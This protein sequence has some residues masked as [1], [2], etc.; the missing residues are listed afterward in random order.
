MKRLVTFC[1]VLLFAVSASAEFTTEEKASLLQSRDALVHALTLIEQNCGVVGTESDCGFSVQAVFE[2]A[3]SLGWLLH[4]NANPN[5]AAGQL[6]LAG[7]RSEVVARA[8][9][10]GQ[11][12]MS[13][14]DRGVYEL[15]RTSAAWKTKTP[16]IAAVAAAGAVN[17]TLLYAD[18]FPPFSVS[19]LGTDPQNQF[20]PHGAYQLAQNELWNPYQ[21]F[22][23]SANDGW[24]SGM[25][26]GTLGACPVYFDQF[27]RALK[28]VTDV[29]LMS[30]HVVEDSG[31]GA[32]RTDAEETL[33]GEARRALTEIHMIAGP[34]DAGT[35]P[36]IQLIFGAQLAAAGCVGEPIATTFGFLGD[37]WRHMDFWG[38]FFNGIK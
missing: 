12:P 32:F 38:G 8:I 2:F 22:E 29:W 25:K 31:F 1:V 3:Q 9:G 24:V 6:L 18:P 34:A 36:A 11:S 13:D 28:I 23:R 7:P 19:G 33:S 10:I 30:A 20:G 37:A 27:S 16:Y 17:R 14:L 5:F 26:N 35:A 4:V 21:Y 15:S